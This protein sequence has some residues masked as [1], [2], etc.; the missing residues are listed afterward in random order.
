M[1]VIPNF[2]KIVFNLMNRLIASLMGFCMCCCIAFAQS[3]K[4][5]G[6]VTDVNGEP[7]IGATVVVKGNSKVGALTDMEGRFVLDKLPEGATRLVV[8]YVGMSPKE[9]EAKSNLSVVLEEESTML[10]ETVVVAFGEQKR[11]AYTG[12]AAVLDAKKIE[13]KQVT[14]VISALQGEAAGVQMVNNSGDPTATPELRIRG[15]SS[16]SA[17]KDP[18]IIVDGAPY[19]GGWN[20]LNPADVANITVLKDAASAAL[21]GARGAN[22]IVLITTKKATAGDATITVDAKMGAVKRIERDYETIDNIGQYYETYYKALYN[23]GIQAQNMTEYAAHAYANSTLGKASNEGGLGY[24]T[25]SVPA[26]QYLIGDNGR[27]NPNATLG[28]LTTCNGA[29]YCLRADDWMKAATRTGSRQEYNINANGGTDKLQFYASLGYLKTEGI[30]RASDFE[31]YSLRLKA[32]YQ[33][34]KWLRL[35]TNV[36]YARSKSDYTSTSSNNVFYFAQ[37]IAPIYP[38]YLRDAQGNILRDSNGKMYDY[39][40]GAVCGLDRPYQPKYNPIQDAELNT[41]NGREHQFSVAG[42]ADITPLEGLK[43]VLN[44]TGTVQSRKFNSATNPFY[45]YSADLYPTGYVYEGSDETFSTNFQELVNYKHAWGEHHAE[46]L[47]GHENYKMNYDYVWGSRKGMASYFSNQTL[48]GAVIISD[49]NSERQDYNSEGY[50]VRAQYDYNEKYFGSASFRRDASS[51]FDPDH[52]WGSFYSVGGAWILTKEEWLSDLKWLNTLKLKAS[53]GQVGNDNISDFLYLDTYKIVNSDGNVG[54][55]LNSIGNKNITWETLNNFNVGFEFELLKSR[56]RGNVEYFDKKTTDMLCFV[57][58]PK[59]MGYGGSYDNIGDMQNKGV[60]VELS[61]DVIRTRNLTWTLSANATCYKNEIVKIAD[62][63]RTKNEEGHAGY[64]SGSYYYGEGLPL[65][66]WYM[67]RYAGVDNEGRSTWYYNQPDGTL[68]TTTSYSD[69]DYYV[70]DDPNPWLYG[71]FGTSLQCYGFDFGIN[72]AYSLGGKAYDYGYSDLMTNPTQSQTGS[73]IHKDMLKAWSESNT[74]SNIP[75]W[76]YNDQNTSAFSDR[77]LQDA[78]WLSL[79][80]I[81]L[82]YTVPKRLLRKAQISNLR[83]YVTA[84]NVYYWTSRKGFDPR[85]S[86]TGETSTSTYSP[87]RTISG[88][89]TMSF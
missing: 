75:R 27:L 49:T 16:I 4:V 74:D 21:Y 62:K 41:S 18:L 66:T 38:V 30:C 25:M 61:G 69:A 28:G 87:S 48:A 65:Y 79:S 46:V 2:S 35:G 32:N 3:T 12:S 33:A 77:F 51:R 64:S 23:Y 29:D 50:F 89:F 54:L 53:F 19:D 78:S 13:Q 37:H 86:F 36:N 67:P 84:E 85:G 59:S 44:G 15:F 47:I 72:F 8:S 55:V 80:N 26:G 14:N 11:S 82:G 6:I 88:G 22:G 76:Q 58:A 5:S 73:A 60:E 31:R 43:I 81:N 52:R 42:N 40:D 68:A 17:G 20:N 24:L 70:C 39:G 63:L 9:V 71:G 1:C 45:G 57:A 34:R 7:I 56:L 83:L 10:E